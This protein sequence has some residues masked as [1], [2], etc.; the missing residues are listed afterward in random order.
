MRHV[1]R[2]HRI[3]LDWLHDWINL[4]PM[5]QIKYVNTAIG[6]HSLEKIINR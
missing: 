1:T 5:L 3:D 6:R 4:D 2:T